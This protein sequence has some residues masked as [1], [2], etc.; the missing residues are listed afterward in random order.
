MKFS[1]IKS[2]TDPLRDSVAEAAIEACVRNGNEYVLNGEE[3]N[4][5]L[6]L[7]SI[8]QPYVFRRKSK[9]VFV[10]SFV[11]GHGLNGNLQ[12]VCYSTLVR[13]LSNLLICAVPK[14]NEIQVYFLTPEAGF[15]QLPC[16]SDKIYQRIL[17]IVSAHFA[18]ENIFS[19]DLPKEYWENSP[20]V[21][22]IQ[23]FGKVLDSLNV[24]PVPFPLRKVLDEREMRHLY[25]I[26]GITG[27][28]YGN[29]SARE[30]LPELGNTTFWMTGRGVNKAK[31]TT[32]GKDIILVKGFDLEQ[33]T[34]FLSSPPEYDRKARVSVDAVE[35]YLIYKTFPDVGAIIHVHAWIEGV[36]CT[37][38]NYPCG[39]RELAEEVVN[40]LKQ[41]ENP[42]CTAVGLKNHGLTITGPS[43]E[44]IF[45]RISD[46]LQTTVTMFA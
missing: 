5:V 38:Q 6:N 30:D 34:A 3:I 4:F 20:V 1:V 15:Y 18:T 9:N 21:K 37:R 7:T 44:E 42:S 29:L 22:K 39:T 11:A 14:N 35:H 13:T 16:D 10:V 28:S 25:K 43:L 19:T 12:S 27:A 33:G 26:F 2:G 8:E 41:T 17:P 24:L 40:L 46:K 23:H 32:V 31:L 45:A 36:L